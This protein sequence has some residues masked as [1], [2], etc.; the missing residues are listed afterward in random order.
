MKRKIQILALLLAGIAGCHAQVP[1]ASPGYSVVL[2]G[3]PPVP[4]G[5]WAGCTVSAPCTYAFY[6]ETIT[7]SACDP[8]S[9]GNYKEISTP[10]ARPT[11]VNFT[12]QNTTGLTKCYDVETIQGSQNSAP[13]NIAGPVV[14][15]G[16]PLAPAL[17]TPAPT[18]ADAEKPA[19]PGVK[20]ALAFAKKLPA[21][22][23]LIAFAPAERNTAR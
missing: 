14:S 11:T 10:T 20:P 8:T 23:A 13:S 4:S 6:A 17:S 7:S 9:S 22:S 3:T 12:D 16:I 15:P 18:I 1:P 2:S 19:S 21:P 5:S